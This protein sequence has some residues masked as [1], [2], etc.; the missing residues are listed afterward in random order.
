VVSGQE[1]PTADVALFTR[2]ITL[3]F[4]KTNYSQKEKERASKLQLYRGNLSGITAKLTT[5]RPIIEEKF[6]DN[7]KALFSELRNHCASESVSSRMVENNAILLSVYETLKDVLEFP[8]ESLDLFTNCADNLFEQNRQISK[9]NEVSVFWSLIEYLSAAGLITEG[10]DYLVKYG[11]K[12]DPNKLLLYINFNR[13][14]PLYREKHNS[15]YGKQGLNKTSLQHYL[16][17][18]H[19]FV[20]TKKAVRF[21]KK[22]TSA[23]VFDYD[24][25]ELSLTGA[26]EATNIEPEMSA[27]E[28]AALSEKE[29]DKPKLKAS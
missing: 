29:T 6:L 21:G 5:L 3:A 8:F 19:T 4:S 9:E 18:H 2:C 11:C 15:Q 24:K 7:Y 10:V 1:L 22:N 14:Y 16:K 13:A 25:L 12:N 27:E 23:F 17:S 20:E 28:W 26:P